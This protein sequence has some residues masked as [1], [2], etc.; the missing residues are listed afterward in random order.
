MNFVCFAYAKETL[1][2]EQNNGDIT[3]EVDGYESRVIQHFQYS[4]GP[5]GGD[6]IEL[7]TNLPSRVD[8]GDTKLCLDT[9]S[10]TFNDNVDN[11]CGEFCGDNN[12]LSAN[13]NSGKSCLL[14]R[15]KNVLITFRSGIES[16]ASKGFK[17]TVR[18]R[19]TVEIAE[20]QGKCLH[21]NA[22]LTT[23]DYFSEI[24]LSD[25]NRNQITVSKILL[26]HCQYCIVIYCAL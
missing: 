13:P 16:K 17:I 6:I 25:G 23:S 1:S 20:E 5:N 14:T 22:R 4:C 26:V 12:F 11:T 24:L 19:P 2:Q 9:I 8:S 21:T 7:S 15:F 3:F 10:I 18:C